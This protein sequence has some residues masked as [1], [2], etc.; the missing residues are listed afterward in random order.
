MK[1]GEERDELNRLKKALSD[2]KSNQSDFTG[3]NG[4]FL[5]P[6]L[7]S[8]TL[9]GANSS[10]LKG[11]DG[12]AIRTFFKEVHQSFLIFLYQSMVY[13]QNVLIRMK[14]DV[15]SFKS[16]PNGFVRQEFLE[17]DVEHGFDRGK[18]VTTE[19]TDDANRIIESVQELVSVKKVY[20]SEVMDNASDGKKKEK[21]LW[22]E[23]HTLDEHE[24]SLLKQTKDDLQTMRTYLSDARLQAKVAH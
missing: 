11:K 18:E 24:T 17:L 12:E 1:V 8:Q 4:I 7:T 22:G 21:I 19:L 2:L 14:D 10:I 23:L 16:Q 13:Y 20:A 15:D 3:N 6:K 9:H 5:K